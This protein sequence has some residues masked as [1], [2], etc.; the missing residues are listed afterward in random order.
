MFSVSV[1]EVTS[2]YKTI[3]ISAKREYQ[4]V[5][6]CGTNAAIGIHVATAGYVLVEG[7]CA[8]DTDKTN[9]IQCVNN[10]CKSDEINTFER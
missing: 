6:D 8:K 5:I 9:W 2:K 4:T 1:V 10:D 7:S 3:L